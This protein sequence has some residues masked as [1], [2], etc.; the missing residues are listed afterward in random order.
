MSVD[1]A[2]IQKAVAAGIREGMGAAHVSTDD[3][4]R[5]VFF[6]DP[7]AHYKHHEFIDAFIRFVDD[8]KTTVFKTIVRMAVYGFILLMVG[9]LIAW[10]KFKTGAV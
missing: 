4:K 1:E 5:K 8:G 6:I 3:A 9:G 2:T 7:E 10:W